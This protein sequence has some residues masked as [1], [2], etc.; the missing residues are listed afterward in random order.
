MVIEDIMVPEYPVDGKVPKSRKKT[1]SPMSR[2]IMWIINT[3]KII[4]RKRW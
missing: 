1:K 4:R 3:K 2:V